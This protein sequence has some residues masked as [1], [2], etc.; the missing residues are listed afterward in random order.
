MTMSAGETELVAPVLP[1]GPGRTVLTVR[2][3][4]GFMR[5]QPLGAFSVV[6]IALLVIAAV[7]APHLHTSDPTAFGRDVLVSPNATH[8]FGTNRQ[9]QDLW[10]RV[11][12]G[13]RP[14][15]LVGTVTVAFG[16][17]GGTVLGII[18]GY[19]GGPLDTAISRIADVLISFPTILFGL[20]MAAALGPGLKSVM[21]AISIIVVP[22]VMRI[23]RGGVLQERERMYVE[24]ARVLGASERRLMFRHILPN[25]MPLVIVVASTTLPAAIL[26]EASLTFLGLGLPLGQPS[27]G[28]DLGADARRYF[29]TAPWLAIFPGVALSLAV[30]AFNLL[31]DSLRDVLDPRL[32]G[33]R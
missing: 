32:R 22:I 25:M 11:L 15:L 20:V 2:G 14:S 16:V 30:L 9:G 26:I 10:S 28:N 12:Y 7:F 17:I 33:A 18:A 13:A 31:G 23:I 3:V 6:I 27:W 24:A 5:H 21:I 19:I 29:T 8:W 1:I 4:R